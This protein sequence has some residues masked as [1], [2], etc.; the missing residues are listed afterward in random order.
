MEP[1]K[2]NEMTE[3]ALRDVKEGRTEHFD[4]VEEL[5]E[6]LNKDDNNAEG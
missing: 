3:E 6:D 1:K 2:P 4:T 5:F